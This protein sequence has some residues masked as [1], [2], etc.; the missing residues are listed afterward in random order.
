M[1]EARLR[2]AVHKLSSCDG[3]QL[4]LLNLGEALLELS[5]VVDIVH[6]AELGPVAD[7]ALADIALV[8]GSISAPYDLQRIRRIREQ[9]RYLIAIGACATSGGPQALRNRGGGPR[10]LAEAYSAP[11]RVAFLAQATPLA[12][13]V[14]VDLELW[15]C[16]VS[17]DQLLTAL[18]DL[19]RGASP[20]QDPKPLCMECKRRL[21]VCTLV[22]RGEPCMGPVTLAG[23]G[24]LCPRFDRACYGCYGPSEQVN[25]A[26]LGRR[27]ATLG[28]APEAVVRRFRFINSGARGFRETA[29]RLEA[30]GAGSS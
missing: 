18:V 7:R 30:E 28:L 14:G 8:E 11:E 21:T 23:C 29:D 26:S 2:L 15:G 4:A 9:S 17:T 5:R 25:G 22:A 27:L 3:C 13:H 16:P 6:F 10:W 1:S 20:R 24:A 12:A 19:I